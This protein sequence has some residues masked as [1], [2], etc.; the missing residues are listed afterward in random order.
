MAGKKLG[1]P[2]MLPDLPEFSEVC[3]VSLF[4]LLGFIWNGGGEVSIFKAAIE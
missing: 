3:E 1:P 4:S 2:V